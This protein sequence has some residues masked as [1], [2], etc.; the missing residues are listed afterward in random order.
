ML[1]F[2]PCEVKGAAV[3]RSEEGGLEAGPHND[4]SMGKHKASEKLVHYRTD[5][6]YICT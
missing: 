5:S 6:L 4:K 3:E 2:G 1:D